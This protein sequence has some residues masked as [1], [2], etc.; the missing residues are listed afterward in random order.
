MYFR[1]TIHTDFD[2]YPAKEKQILSSL[3]LNFIQTKLT[4]SNQLMT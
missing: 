2:I 3:T 4:F 1:F